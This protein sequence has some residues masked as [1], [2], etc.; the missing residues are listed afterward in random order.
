[1]K[2]LQQILNDTRH[3]RFLLGLK[4]TYNFL[5]IIIYTTGCIRN[6]ACQAYF[7]FELIEFVKHIFLTM[8]AEHKSAFG[9]GT[10]PTEHIFK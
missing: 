2:I 10:S 6:Y 8:I 5:S 4:I 7:N 3:Q 1:M 9:K